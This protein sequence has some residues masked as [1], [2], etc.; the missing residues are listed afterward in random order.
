MIRGRPET[1]DLPQTAFS[2]ILYTVCVIRMNYESKR[3]FTSFLDAGS[4]PAIST[5]LYEFKGP[6]W[7]C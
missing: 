3:F 5:K 1:F 7:A 4:I 6:A 2:F